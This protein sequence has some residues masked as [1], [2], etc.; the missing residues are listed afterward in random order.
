[1]FGSWDSE[2][3]GGWDFEEVRTTS[4]FCHPSGQASMCRAACGPAKLLEEFK[5]VSHVATRQEDE[6][7]GRRG[8]ANSVVSA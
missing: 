4:A 2:V 5:Q 1:M 6:S 7:A 8:S 3:R